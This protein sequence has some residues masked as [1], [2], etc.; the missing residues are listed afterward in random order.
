MFCDAMWLRSRVLGSSSM[1]C[2][3]VPAATKDVRSCGIRAVSFL[4]TSWLGNLIFWVGSAIGE[5][6]MSTGLM[7]GL[8]FTVKKVP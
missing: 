5:G 4:V 2:V 7:S 6:V 3:I 8:P 1:A